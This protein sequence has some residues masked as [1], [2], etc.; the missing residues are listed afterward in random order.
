MDGGPVR[1]STRKCSQRASMRGG[2]GSEPPLHA[3]VD[4]DGV[5]MVREC[6]SQINVPG[7]AATSVASGGAEPGGA[8][9]GK[10]CNEE[11]CARNIR[12]NRGHGVGMSDRDAFE[13][14]L[15]ALHEATFGD[16]C[17]PAAA[18][19]I[20]EACRIKGN[21]LTYG[22]GTSRKDVAI[23]L[24]RLCYRG[25]RYEE[26][27]RMYFADYYTRDERV[28]RFRALPDSRLVHTADLFTDEEKKVSAVYNEA[29]V[30]GDMQSC[31]TVRLAGPHGSRIFWS[32]GDPV[33]G[34]GWSFEQTEMIERLL[35]HLR[36]YVCVRQALAD[37][38]GLK[39]SLA[40]LLDN[41][42]TG[43]IQLDRHGR[44][45][46]VNDRARE[47]VKA[48]GGVFDQGGFLRARAS[49]DNDHLQGL[50][51]R[52]LPP[53]GGQG[54][55]GSMVLKR[56]PG[57]SRL[58]LHVIPVGHRDADVLPS[59]VAALVLVVDPNG[60]VQLDPG[61]VAAAL[62][63]SPAESRVAVLLGEGNRG[64]CAHG[65]W[66][67]PARAP[68]PRELLTTPL[69]LRPIRQGGE[70]PRAAPPCPPALRAR[71]PPKY[72]RRKVGLGRALPGPC[73]L[74]GGA[75][76]AARLSQLS[77]APR[78]WKAHGVSDWT[79][80]DEAGRALWNRS[81]PRALPISG[82]R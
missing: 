28:P 64:R 74:G 10:G 76:G 42:A 34:D 8:D 75:R 57:I 35:P 19:L 3:T 16:D 71:C 72:G 25:Q 73:L 52:A 43:V 17:W 5:L 2:V 14:V 37:A 58:V 59:Q 77:R 48:A 12:E 81:R 9:R 20:D 30:R 62:G 32:F 54:A 36:Q 68:L 7:R 40:T 55:S 41:T 82:S 6:A 65:C 69:V 63:L 39:S 80:G 13:G 38:D 78:R 27:E 18:H 44:I 22:A 47:M 15:A 46:A 56:P 33:E 1:L 49:S 11:A 31:L 67:T 21:M 79:P 24:T 53:S 60:H 61:L 4:R 50:V 26:G 45:V 70:M 51:A 29:L 23:F 66:R